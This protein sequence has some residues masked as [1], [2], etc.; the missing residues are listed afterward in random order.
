M[1]IRFGGEMLSRVRRPDKHGLEAFGEDFDRYP[2]R[3]PCE[4]LDTDLSTCKSPHARDILRPIQQEGERSL[5]FS[6]PD[7]LPDVR[8]KLATMTN[9]EREAWYASKAWF[10]VRNAMCRHELYYQPLNSLVVLRYQR[11][12]ISQWE[13]TE[14]L[15]RGLLDH[16]QVP[17]TAAGPLPATNHHSK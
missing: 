5:M 12:F 9:T 13:R 3:R 10:G 11:H 4:T 7:I 16:A 15:V 6:D 17:G 8:A 2:K 14:Q 1:A